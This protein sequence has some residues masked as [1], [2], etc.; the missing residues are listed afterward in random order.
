MDER[1]SLCPPI[2]I[3][4]QVQDERKGPQLLKGIPFVRLSPSFNK[5]RMSGQIDGRMKPSPGPMQLLKGFRFSG[6]SFNKF[7]MSGQ[8]DGRMKPSPRP[9][10]GA[11]AYSNRPSRPALPSFPRKRESRGCLPRL[12]HHK[13][14]PFWIPACAGMTVLYAIALSRPSPY[15]RPGITSSANRPMERITCGWVKSPQAKMELK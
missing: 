6:P 4:Q 7:R 1:V 5:F 2:P 15:R 12:R 8:I 9:V 10:A 13:A 3:L 11:M 14:V